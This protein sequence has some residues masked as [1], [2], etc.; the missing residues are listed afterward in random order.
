VQTATLIAALHFGGHLRVSESIA[1]VYIIVIALTSPFWSY[2]L[3]LFA[4]VLMTSPV[5]SLGQ[6]AA[7]F[8][9][10]DLLDEWL[11]WFWV[12]HA[13]AI[14]TRPNAFRN[15]D[16][17]KYFQASMLIA[18]YTCIAL[19]IALF[20]AFTLFAI[21]RVI[22]VPAFGM[23]DIGGNQLSLRGQYMIFIVLA[24]LV[25]YGVAWMILRPI[26][27][28]FIYCSKNQDEHTLRYELV[29]VRQICEHLLFRDGVD[30][31][32]AIPKSGLSR[33]KKEFEVLFARWKMQEM[34][35]HR[36]SQQKLDELLQQRKLLSED[37][38]LYRSCF[39]DDCDRAVIESIDKLLAGIPLST[40]R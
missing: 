27:Y 19:P 17:I 15:M 9:I 6:Y 16:W 4:N 10:R 34:R 12:P 1:G 26:A 29:R 18:V 40:L 35:A 20:P 38:Y 22:S 32:G 25:A 30:I 2:A 37:L 24:I 13:A 36:Q 5:A 28:A 3:F 33:L 14:I 7:P 23:R 31:R 21:L 11:G 8:L 39:S